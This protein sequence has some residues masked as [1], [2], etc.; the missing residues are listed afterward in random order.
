MRL[1][2][3]LLLPVLALG[4]ASPPAPLTLDRALEL[5]TA[6]RAEQIAA[7]H[8]IEAQQAGVQ[9]AG[10]APNPVL[11]IQTENWRASDK[12]RPSQDLDT[13]VSVSQRLELGGKRRLRTEAAHAETGIAEAEREVLRWEIS[14]RVAT[15]WWDALRAQE[16]SKLIE[17]SLGA[18]EE[19]VRYHDV[20]WREGEG[21]EIDLVKVRV[22]LE[23]ERRRLLEAEIAVRSAKHRLFAEMATSLPVTVRLVRPVESGGEEAV[24]LSQALAR[25]PDLYLQKVIAERDEA[26]ASVERSRSTADLTPYVGYKR[27][28]GLNTVIGGVSIPLMFRDRNKGAIEQAVA[29]TSRQRQLARALEIRIRS[30]VEA[31][32]AERE[33]RRMAVDSLTTL[34]ADATEAHDITQAAYREG[35]VELLFVIDAWR[36]LNEARML[37]LQVEFDYERSRVEARRVTGLTPGDNRSIGGGK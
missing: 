3:T 26:Q 12:F 22:E 25:R 28:N 20:R 2:I 19:L 29:R 37:G 11:S 35:G 17:Q 14:N 21:A 15:A 31:A 24:S 33:S 36:T 9:Q 1:L 23:K 27:T 6:N 18:V 5:A 34:V 32:M 13:F 8:L 7:E 30:E 10:R 4:Q 16:A